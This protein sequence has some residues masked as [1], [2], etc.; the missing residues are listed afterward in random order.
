MKILELRFKN[1][2]SLYGEWLIDFTDPEYI[3]NGIFVLSGPT[4]AGKSTILDG[5]CLALYGATP[6]LGKITKSNN[7]IMS[8][9]TGECYAEVLFESRA[10]RFRCHFSQHRSRKKPEGA[11]QNPRHEIADGV[12]GKIVEHQLKKVAAAV[13][14]KTG[15]DFDR[16]TRSILLAQGG[17]DTFLKADIEQKSTILE[18]ITGTEIYSEISRQVHERMRQE[19]GKL[20]MLKAEIATVELMSPEEEK[21]LQGALANRQKQEKDLSHKLSKTEQVITWLGLIAGLQKEIKNLSREEDKLKADIDGFK[22][23]K[24]LL[25]RAKKAASLAGVYATLVAIRKQQAEDEKALEQEKT[26]FPELEQRCV[27]QEKILAE[28]EQLSRQSK[29]SWQKEAPLLQQVR[30]LDQ[31]LRQKA[32]TIREFE[33]SCRNDA[34]QI[35]KDEKSL[36]REKEKLT[37]AQKVFTET[38]QY[39]KRHGRDEWL[40]GG[41]GGIEEQFVSLAAKQKDIK[42]K[43]TDLVKADALVRNSAEKLAAT[44][45]QSDSYRQEFKKAEQRVQ[46]GE[47]S[48]TKLLAGKLLREYRAEK[49]SLQREKEYLAR[50]ASLEE[51]R[52]A[53]EDGKPCPLCGSTEH[54]YAEGNVPASDGIEERIAQLDKL[55]D[56]VEKQEAAI[57]KLKKD[58]LAALKKMNE[59]EKLEAMITA[60]MQA[61]EKLVVGLKDELALLEKGFAELKQLIC[62]K[63]QPLGICGIEEEQIADLQEA[64]KKRRAKWQE[65]H[66]K[67]QELEQQITAFGSEIKK[68]E[69]GLEIRQKELQE[70]KNNLQR[71]QNKYSDNVVERKELY[72][73]KN[74]D[75]E[76]RRLQ[77]VVANAEEEENKARI[78]H[79]KLQQKLNTVKSNIESLESRIDNRLTELGK[80][81]ASF[82][83]ALEAAG[84]ENEKQFLAARLANTELESLSLRARELENAQKELAIRIK[85]REERLAVEQG[86]KLS[87]KPL[88][89]LEMQFKDYD[90]SL[91][92]LR[93]QIAAWQYKLA[94]HQ[95]TREQLKERQSLIEAQTK[96]SSR[97]EK[98]HG[99]IGS[100][101]GKKYRN[102]AQGLT[103]ELM[104]SHA[105]RQLAKMSDR[106]LLIRDAAQPLVL[107]VLDNYQGGEIR[108]S[109]NLSG[110]ESFIVS[111]SLALGLAKMASRKVSVDSLFLDEGFGTLDEEALATALS[112]LSGLH[113]EGKLIG[114][115]SHISALKERISTQISILPLSGGKSTIQGP[116]CQR[117]GEV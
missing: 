45:K 92:E 54:P 30:L 13:E 47:G 64:L 19:Q 55:I 89:E 16:F 85:D 4:G 20:E 32:E 75:N 43:K 115:I 41:F 5:I 103:F 3:N 53:L 97:W 79:A 111:L 117:A 15:M 17:F 37:S 8:R 28:V 104:V 22:P 62:D 84:F 109:K 112:T 78:L 113:Q 107:N 114:V 39:L 35:E 72:G 76:E 6:R 86:R 38:E 73:D 81:E 96:E 48:L 31:G 93:Q 106:Y 10:G 87:D 33:E 95:K 9:Q 66:N 23:Q 80:A 90:K 26:V 24:E 21:D 14:E 61:A 91:Q 18:Q 70:K 83:S 63:L 94:E 116:G 67:K 7:D 58:E 88:A 99:L 69:G 110:G 57:E 11:L 77:K 100:A 2:N 25:A 51:H 74:P 98:L 1:L 60:D 56:K 102:F 29:E 12:S 59:A 65:Y 49:D 42:Q 46:E 82:L 36:M 68:L 71:L 105:N 50:I 52:N 101:D 40:I 34:R 27:R 108:S 44:R